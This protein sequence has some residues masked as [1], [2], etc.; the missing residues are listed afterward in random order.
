MTRK[1][2]GD[3]AESVF[4]KVPRYNKDRGANANLD[5]IEKEQAATKKRLNDRKKKQ[6]NS[7]F[8]KDK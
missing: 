4:G 8:L 6:P 7:V 5:K 2:I 1:P 3:I